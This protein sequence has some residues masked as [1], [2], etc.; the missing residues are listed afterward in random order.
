MMEKQPTPDNQDIT[1]GLMSDDPNEFLAAKR[2]AAFEESVRAHAYRHKEDYT[3]DSNHNLPVEKNP[4]VG[5]NFDLDQQPPKQRSR[6]EIQ[7]MVDEYK[8]NNPQDDRSAEEAFERLKRET[9]GR[10]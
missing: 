8:K 5:A 10:S 7:K 4:L 2:R 9:E 1:K 6:E 3:E